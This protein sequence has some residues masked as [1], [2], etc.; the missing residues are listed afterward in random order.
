[1]PGIV[2]LST[3]T[4]HHRYFLNVLER[5]GV[6]LSGYV[7]ETV[8][9]QA[10]FAT[11]PLN[12]V[13]ER[14]FEQRRFFE[15]VPM[16]L[17]ETKVHR[18]DRC[19]SQAG[20]ALLDRLQPDFGVVF[21]TGRLSEAVIGRFRHGL[22]NVHRGISQAYRGLDSDLWAI[23]HGDYGN[24][25][26]TIHRVEPTLDTGPIVAQRTLPLNGSMRSWQLRYHTTVLATD[27]VARALEDYR[28]GRLGG[29]PQ[30]Q[31]G[32]YY[33][34]MPLELKREVAR[35]FDRYCEGLHA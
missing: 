35:K 18:V 9:T 28:C 32:R 7:F 1:M 26:V 8:H 16:A 15:T 33:S 24:L 21:G 29:V 4:L 34:F 30:T 23:Y 2:V 3:D 19:G 11:G 31:H 5:R 20:V 10:P 22:I 14:D 17:Q 12:E 25:G 6:P 13:E 27:L